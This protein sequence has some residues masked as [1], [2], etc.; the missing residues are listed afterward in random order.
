MKENN[1]RRK[2]L[3]ELTAKLDKAAKAYYQESS[4]IMSNKEYDELYD[5]LEALE[6]ELGIVLAGKP[7]GQVGY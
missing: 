6:K 4:E 3:E 7:Y 1:D 5:E 2:R